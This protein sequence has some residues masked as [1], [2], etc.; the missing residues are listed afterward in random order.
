MRPPAG[1]TLGKR[2]GRLGYIR[3]VSFTTAAY[4][5]KKV[6]K[7]CALSMGI[8][9]VLPDMAAWSNCSNRRFQDSNRSTRHGG[10]GA[11]QET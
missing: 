10:G 2:P 5:K 4:E 6:S 3:R 11:L 9:E 1:T 7:E 8:W